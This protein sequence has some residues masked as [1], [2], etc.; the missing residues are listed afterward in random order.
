MAAGVDF[1]SFHLS[2]FCVNGSREKVPVWYLSFTLMWSEAGLC[3]TSIRNAL[4][5]SKRYPLGDSG[6]YLE[7]DAVEQRF[8]YALIRRS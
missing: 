7:R 4:D 2:F 6:R 1:L 8:E 5:G 3:F